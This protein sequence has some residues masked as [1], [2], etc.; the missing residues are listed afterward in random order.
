MRLVLAPTVRAVEGDEGAAGEDQGETE[1]AGEDQGGT[2]NRSHR[3]TTH[4]NLSG[5]GTHNCQ[6][7]ASKV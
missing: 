3:D 4:N 7:T 1:E 2:V 5:G 6:A